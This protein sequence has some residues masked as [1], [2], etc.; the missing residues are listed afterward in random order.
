MELTLDTLACQRGGRAVFRDLSF[1]LGAGQAAVL[2]G[3]NGVG[4]STLLRVLAGM[5][6][7]IGGDARLGEVSLIGDRGAFQ[8]QVAYGGHLD[9]VKPALT[10][11]QNLALWAGIYGTDPARADAALAFFGLDGIADRPAAQCSA[12]QKR[13]L[14]LSR[15]MVIDR[16]L[17]LLDEPT[18]SL[19]T[20][21]TALVA[22]LVRGH[23]AGGGMALI[24]THIDL[25]L[26]D[27]P[28][29]LMA[30]PETGQRPAMQDAFLDG[31]W[32]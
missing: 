19:D 13:R 20:A 14:G 4:K 18:V 32:T 26:E 10:V 7:P 25:G 27:P 8:E 30:P 17:W 6:T 31:D 2:R 9:A 1:V 12:G 11:V 15:L 24:A 29:L 23:C 22:D 16:P 28:V 21:S 5:I 3:P